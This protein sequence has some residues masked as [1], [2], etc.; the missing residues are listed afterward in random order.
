[1]TNKTITV[2]LNFFGP[3]IKKED[4]HI[5]LQSETT[6]PIDDIRK[7]LLGSFFGLPTNALSEKILERYIEVTTE[8]LHLPV[9]PH[10]ERIFK[11]ILKPLKSAKVNYC[12]GDYLS[13]IASCGIVG[14]MLAILLWKLGDVRLNN[15]P[16]TERDEEFVELKRKSFRRLLHRAVI[17]NLAIV[18]L[19]KAFCL[20]V[21]IEDWAGK[22]LGR[23]HRAYIWTSEGT[24]D[25]LF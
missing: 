7:R 4:I 23:A 15:K 12:L 18:A 14:E 13:T 5:I 11:R 6:K 25:P 16:M 10:T 3:Y 20:P 2:Q 24:S 17:K 22:G 19:N 8:E 9:V 21:K 1:M